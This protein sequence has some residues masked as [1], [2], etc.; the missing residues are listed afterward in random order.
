MILFWAIVII[1]CVF[2]GLVVFRGAPYVPSKKTY[3]NQAFSDLYPL[4]DKDVLVDVGSGDGVV[5]RSAT[6]F[7]A[8]AIGY[9]INPILVIMM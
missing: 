7:G 9:E 8:L 1:L 2:F 6:K 3:I 4:T 5:L